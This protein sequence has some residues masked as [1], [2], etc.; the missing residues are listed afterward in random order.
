MQYWARRDIPFKVGRAEKALERL[1]SAPTPRDY[2][3]G[4]LVAVMTRLNYEL[5]STGGSGRKFIHRTTQATLML[6]E[7]HPGSILKVYQVRDVIRF[8]RQEGTLDENL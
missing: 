7:P 5:K 6:H 8:L 3:W 4:E 2:T 1:L